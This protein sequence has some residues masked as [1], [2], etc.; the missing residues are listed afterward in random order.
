MK[1]LI[2]IE[3]DEELDRDDVR[4]GSAFRTGKNEIF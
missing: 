4:P 3:D 1:Q 2:I